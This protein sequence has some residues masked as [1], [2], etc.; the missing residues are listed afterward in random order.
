LEELPFTG[1]DDQVLTAMREL[2][3]MAAEFVTD[4][5]F[6]PHVEFSFPFDPLERV[7]NALRTRTDLSEIGMDR[8]V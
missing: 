2:Y 5:V 4:V 3:E 6:I 1:E 7:T 8:K